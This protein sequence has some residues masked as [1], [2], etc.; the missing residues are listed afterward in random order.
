MRFEKIIENLD[1]AIGIIE[2]GKITYVNNLAATYLGWSKEELIGKSFIDIVAPVYRDSLMEKYEKRIKEKDAQE[3]RYEVEILTKEGKRKRITVITKLIDEESSAV[4]VIGKDV[5]EWERLKNELFLRNRISCALSKNL[6]LEDAL[7]AVLDVYMEYISAVAGVIKLYDDRDRKLKVVVQKNI[8]ALKKFIS[9]TKP[10]EGLSGYSFQSGE[11]LMLD[12]SKSEMG[13]E[14]KDI[15]YLLTLPL[16]SRERII[17]VIQLFINQDISKEDVELLKST[18]RN[19]GISVEN[20]LL[21]VDLRRKMTQR[22]KLYELMLELQKSTGLDDVLKKI[23]KMLEKMFSAMSVILLYDPVD[24]VLR[25]RYASEDLLKY[26]KL[27]E[28]PVGMGITGGAA[29][30]RRM[31]VVQDVRKNGRYVEGHPDVASE[32]A[33]PLIVENELIGVMDIESKRKNAFSEEDIQLAA[34]FAQ[35]VA[36]IIKNAQ[37]FEK[38]KKE[39]EAKAKLFAFLSHEIKNPL[40]V[41]KSGLW[42]IKKEKGISRKEI[43]E[44]V[45]NMEEEIENIEKM[46]NNFLD[47]AKLQV[48]YSDAEMVWVDIENLLRKIVKSYERLAMEKNVSLIFNSLLT[49]PLIMSHPERLRH[50]FSNLINNSIKYNVK[51][52]IVRITVQEKED[53]INVKIEDTGIGIPKDKLQV[54]FEPFYKAKKGEGAGIGL[55]VVR[56]FVYALGGKIRIESE[57]GK[58]TR[59]TVFLPKERKK[60]VEEVA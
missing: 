5:L 26:V 44:Q 60:K 39:N 13:K 47:L 37:L 2:N 48:A 23:V 33:I 58:G 41:I 54:I 25:I 11:V 7:Y 36:M 18:S 4:L 50:I 35:Q 59:F 17:G 38:L 15:K 52:G 21:F 19:I 1:I 42:Y 9:D 29:A 24:E 40:S 6:S 49:S 12:I 55:A 57:E 56:E 53:G 30:S 28:L 43:E 51:G 10:G 45:E 31:V 14:I 34:I 8:G 46:V 3:K 22:T 20:L 16:I 27:K 32:L